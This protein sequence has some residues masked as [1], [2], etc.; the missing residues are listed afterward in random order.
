MQSRA[1]LL[2]LFFA[3]L[4]GRIYSQGCS[5]A[6]VCSVGLLSIVEFRYEFLPSDKSTLA[7]LDNENAD[8]KISFDGSTPD[9]ASKKTNEVVKKDSVINTTVTNVDTSKKTNPTSKNFM[10]YFYK[11]PKCQF[12]LSSS[13]GIGDEKA[14]IIITQFEGSFSIVKQKLFAQIKVPYTM[15]NG[16]LANTSGLSDVTLSLSY[17]LLN[18]NGKNLSVTGGVKLPTNDANIKKDS[19]PLPM[20]YQTSLGATD[21]L[22]GIKYSCKKWDVSFGY[23][24]S[25]NGNKNEYLYVTQ[26]FEPNYNN[27]S[28]SNQ[29]KRADDGIFRINRIYR[30]KR[31]VANTGLLFIYHLADDVYTNNIGES[32]KSIG[33]KGL[34]INLNFALSVPIYKNIDFFV[35][36]GQPVVARDTQPDGLKRY[37]FVLG[38]FKY[39]IL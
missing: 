4:S 31:V 27:Y 12:Q 3:L 15:V 17:I 5:D 16:P 2:V 33:S 36:Y 18:K 37:I 11:Y 7:K 39:S 32:V 6:G 1:T 24:H 19:L 26:P 38:G 35:V 34:T 10:N 28:E 21:I 13:L 20:V 29:T 30:I 9:T 14:S 23:Q 8:I 22:A 25:F